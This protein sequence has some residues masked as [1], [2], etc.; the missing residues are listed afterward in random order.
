MI[1]VANSNVKQDVKLSFP[2]ESN[3]RQW[4]DASF[5]IKQN[6]FVEIHWNY[7]LLN[8]SLCGGIDDLSKVNR[9]LGVRT[10]I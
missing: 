9:H 6:S 8:L 10:V 5:F 3:D 1:F 4:Y 2:L 7:K